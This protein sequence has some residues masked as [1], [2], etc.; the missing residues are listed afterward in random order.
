VPQF[1][2][3]AEAYLEML[4]MVAVAVAARREFVLRAVLDLQLVILVWNGNSQVVALSQYLV[5]HATIAKL[6]LDWGSARPL[7]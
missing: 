3:V 5:I 6:S 7:L 4:L 2:V 1:V